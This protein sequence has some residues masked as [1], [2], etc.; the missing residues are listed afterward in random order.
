MIEFG[1]IPVAQMNE[2][3][4]CQ[5]GRLKRL[6]HLEQSVILNH[7]MSS[8]VRPNLET[9]TILSWIKFLPYTKNK[10]SIVT[11]HPHGR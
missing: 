6:D 1:N 4:Y 5:W 11:T 10:K 7:D 9:N 2:M 8:L 3:I